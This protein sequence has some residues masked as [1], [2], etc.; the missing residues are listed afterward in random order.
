MDL[1]QKFGHN[2]FLRYVSV[3]RMDIGTLTS[4]NRAAQGLSISG[5]LVNTALVLIYIHMYIYIYM[6]IKYI[7]TVAIHLF[8]Y[9]YLHVDLR[10]L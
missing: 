3:M 4:S 1:T 5:F 7:I 8:E 2:L 10:S 6:Y 9:V